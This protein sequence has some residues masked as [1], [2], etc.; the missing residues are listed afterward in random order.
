MRANYGMQA[1]TPALPKIASCGAGFQP[2]L[3]NEE[4]AL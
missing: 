3:L 2:A 1:G 4:F